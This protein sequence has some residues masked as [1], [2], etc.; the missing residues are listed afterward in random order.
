[1]VERAIIAITRKIAE[2]F[3]IEEVTKGMWSYV[4]IARRGS[5]EILV[6]NFSLFFH[7]DV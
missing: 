5:F 7:E 3:M 1:M 4:E 6:E 2:N